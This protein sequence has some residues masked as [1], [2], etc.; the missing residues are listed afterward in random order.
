MYKRLSVIL[1]V[2]LLAFALPWV[3]NTLLV[4]Q[5][6]LNAFLK[7]LGNHKYEV[8]LKDLASLAVDAQTEDLIELRRRF[9]RKQNT[10]AVAINKDSFVLTTD[11][12]MHFSTQPSVE[13]DVIRERVMSIPFKRENPSRAWFYTN[14]GT[15]LQG[16]VEFNCTLKDDNGV[17]VNASEEIVGILRKRLEG[18]GLSEPQVY[19]LANGDVQVVIP[20]GTDADAARTRK[21]LE[22]TGKLEFREIFP[23]FDKKGTRYTRLGSSQVELRKNKW[24]L[25]KGSGLRGMKRNWIIA[26][27]KPPRGEE[28]TIFYVMGPP[29]LSGTDVSTATRTTHEGK[30]AV[31]ITF[32]S[33]GASKNHNFTSEIKRKFSEN[34]NSFSEM[35]AIMLDGQIESALHIESASSRNCVVSGSFSEEEVASLKTVLLAGALAVK[36]EVTSERRTGASLGADTVS[37]AMWSMVA[38]LLCIFIFILGYYWWR[39]G[40]VALA[41]LTACVGLVIAAISAFGVTLTLP[42]LAGLVLTV[43]MAVDANILIFERIRE[44]SGDDVDVPTSINAGYGRAF[45]TIFDANIT[46]FLT[47][48]LLYQIGSGP[49]KSFGLTLMIGIATSVFGAVYLGRF[50]TEW[51]HRNQREV[52]VASWIRI[53]KISFID[54]RKISAA[55]SIILILGSLSY[56]FGGDMRRHFDI[57]FTGG[58][59]VQVTFTET[60]QL[61]AVQDLV[62]E[63]HKVH[64]EAE[65]LINPDNMQIQPYAAEHAQESANGSRQYI[66]KVRDDIAVEI[67][68]KKSA[69]EQ[70]IADMNAEYTARVKKLEK[71]DKTIDEKEARAFE[72]D[73]QAYNIEHVEPLRDQLLARVDILKNQLAEAFPGKIS[74][75]GSELLGAQWDSTINTLKLSFATLGIAETSTLNQINDRLKALPEVEDAIATVIGDNDGL[76][77]ALHLVDSAATEMPDGFLADEEGVIGHGIR[78]YLSDSGLTGDQLEILVARGT[79]L[80]GLCDTAMASVGVQVAAP[81]PS[82]DFF[83]PQVADQMKTSAL[84]AMFWSLLAILLYIAMRFE[85]RYGVGAI[86][87]LVHDVLATIGLLAICGLRIDLTV[88]AG[89]LTIIG[90]SLND[91][92]VVFDRIRENMKRD[93]TP[94]IETIDPAIRETMSRTVLTSFT[95]IIVVLILFLFGGEGIHSFS[96][97]M[98]IG[99]L[100][101]TYS[102]VFVAAPTLLFF[103][104]KPKPPPEEDTTNTEDGDV[105]NAVLY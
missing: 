71:E 64:P 48:F 69:H 7:P 8:A 26:P 105:K 17:K 24:V 97:T 98:L 57:D 47:A 49:I 31:G 99:L 77:I 46:T 5:Q 22:T 23:V 103:K 21:V 56:F 55:F 80:A 36:P 38:S 9:R 79:N 28:P 54:K 96:G 12:K 53:P 40:V 86:I 84:W 72:A 95:T 58:S 13:L 18:Q 65:S 78:A 93:G 32:T 45:L 85:F 27:E 42:G 100:L 91:T 61:E 104:D 35:M 81:Y 20:G 52:K 102:S 74:A 44:E 19:R 76:Q 60:Q 50:V 66:F 14:Y 59:M 41:S 43:G 16:G 101:G 87:A 89:I 30:I 25:A 82:S 94:M 11:K 75:V 83:S 73:V 3:E 34:S 10:S 15:D 39:F 4:G 67:E 33:S 62:E 68:K 51:L 6:D 1:F 2:I 70:H 92:I 88:V 29:R 90:Y 63:A 37:K